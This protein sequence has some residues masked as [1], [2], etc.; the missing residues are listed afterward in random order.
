[1]QRDEWGYFNALVGNILRE[2]RYGYLLDGNLRAD[3]ASYDQPDN[4][5]ALLRL[6]HNS[7]CGKI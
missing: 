6:N 4:I 3:A 2:R 5:V 7:L 1:M